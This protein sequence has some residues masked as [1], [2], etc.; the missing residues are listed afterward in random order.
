MPFVGEVK[1]W[2]RDDFFCNRL[3]LKNRLIL[4]GNRRFASKTNIFFEIIY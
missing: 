2:E 1:I 3:N 4:S